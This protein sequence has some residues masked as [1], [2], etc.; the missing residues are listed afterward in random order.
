LV[1]IVRRRFVM[2]HGVNCWFPAAVRVV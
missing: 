1:Q 2:G